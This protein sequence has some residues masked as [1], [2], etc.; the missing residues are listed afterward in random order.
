MGNPH[1][2]SEQVQILPVASIFFL[3]TRRDQEPVA[4]LSPSRKM[5]PGRRTV[6]M[7]STPVK[8]TLTMEVTGNHFKHEESTIPL[9]PIKMV[10]SKNSR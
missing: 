5:K 1:T 4:C 7:L 8:E 2:V 3:L 9:S 6:E 10:S